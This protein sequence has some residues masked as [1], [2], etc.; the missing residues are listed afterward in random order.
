PR[1]IAV[2]GASNRPRSVGLALMTNLV[3]AG[4]KGPIYPVNP[5]ES[6]VAGLAC[7]GDVALLPEAPDLAVIATPPDTVAPIIA[8]LGRKGTKAAVV[9][10]AGFEGG[11]GAARK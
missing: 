7:L 2:V 6:A 10:T 11:E 4:F 3:K 9:L 1:S 5:N 8:E